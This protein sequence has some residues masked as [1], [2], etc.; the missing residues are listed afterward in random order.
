MTH[1]ATR[2]AQLL[3]YIVEQSK[4]VD[5]HRFK[6]STTTGFVQDR[7]TLAHLPG[8]DFDL[9]TAGDHAWLRVER[10]TALPPPALPAAL[11]EKVLV[12]RDPNGPA[13]HFKDHP[14]VPSRTPVRSPA[15]VAT[16][17][18]ELAL[19]VEPSLA[20][21]GPSLDA[22]LADY[23]GLWTAWAAGESPRRKAIQLYTDLFSLKHQLGA[24]DTARPQEL[25]WGMGVTTWTLRDE[26]GLPVDV[27]YPLLTQ[28]M[29]IA[30]EDG[31]L[32]I[33]L[34]P[35]GVAA[36]FEFDAFSAWQLPGADQVEKVAAQSLTASADRPVTPFDAGSYEPVLKLVAG[37]LHES[38]RYLSGQA[39][40]PVAGESLLVTD[41]WVLLTRPRSNNSLHEDIGRLQKRI[42]DGAPLPAGA[43]AF[44]TAP[45]DSPPPQHDPIA[46]RGLCG[47]GPRDASA[48]VRDLYFPLPYN[49]EQVAILEQLERSAG[50]VVQGPPGTGKTHTIANVVCHYLATGRRVLVTAKGEQALEVLQSKIPAAVR[51]LTVALLS[52]DREGLSSFGHSIEAIIQTVSQLQPETAQGEIDALR[53]AVHSTHAELAV[54]DRCVDD[55]A[56]SQLSDIDVDGVVM[57]AESMAHLVVDGEARHRWFD[58]VLTLEPVHAPP[59]TAAEVEVLR[60]ARRSVGCDLLHANARLPSS[61]SLPDARDIGALHTVL[62]GLRAIDTAEACGGLPALR[63]LS[64]EVLADARTLLESVEIATLLAQELEET[65]YPWAAPLRRKCRLPEFTSERQALESLFAEADGLLVDRLQFLKR[66]VEIPHGAVSS[67]RFTA[68]VWRAAETGKPFGLIAHSAVEARAQIAAVRISGLRPQGETDWSHVSRYL[69]LHDR[70]HSFNVRWNQFAEVLSLPLLEDEGPQAL[71]TT[72]LLARCA[73]KAH[74][75]ATVHDLQ[76]PVIAERVFANA[77]LQ[78]LRGGNAADLR[79]VGDHLRSHLARAELAQA[80]LML[81]TLQH[82]LAGSSGHVAESLRQFVTEELGNPAVGA[83]RAMAV[84]ADLIAEVHRM[85]GMAHALGVINAV[86]N[87]FEQAGAP[88]MARRIRTEATRPAGEDHVLPSTWRDAWNW[89]RLKAHLDSIDGRDELLTLTARRRVLEARLGRLYEELVS[90]SAWLSTKLAASPKVLSALEAC[91]TAIHR[92]GQGTGSNASRYRR[93]AQNAMQDAQAAVP[94]WVMSHAK[95]SETLPALL[96]SF[97]LVIVDEASQ[98][99]LWALPA[100]L[101]GKQMLVVGDDKQVSP[102]GGFISAGRIQELASRFLSGQPHAPSLTPEK[103]LY[104]MAST[105]FAGSKVMLREHFRCAPAII[106]YS[107]A[108]FY[109]GAMQ[110]L[111]IPSKSERLDPPLVDVFVPSGYR[112]ASDLNRP[113]ADAILKQIE[114]LLADPA[115]ANRSLGVVS[116]LGVNQARHIETLVRSSCDPA[117]LIRRRFRCGDARAFQGSE[118]DILFLSMVAAPKSCKALAGNLFTQRFNVAASRAR[119]RMYLVRSV[120]MSDLSP[121]DLRAGLLAHFGATGGLQRAQTSVV[122][123]CESGFERSVYTELFA[124]GFRVFPQVRAGSFFIDLVVEG[125]N[126]SRLAIECDGDEFHRLDRWQADMNR[127]RVLERAG[128]TFWRCFAS[129]WALRK[130]EVVPELLE[131]LTAMGIEPVSDATSTAAEAPR[132]Q[133]EVYPPA[134]PTACGPILLNEERAA[135]LVGK[136][137][138][139]VG[140]HWQRRPSQESRPTFLVLSGGTPQ[141]RRDA[142]WAQRRTV[143]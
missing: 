10:L 4:V 24:E 89:A 15:A 143:R 31:S 127:Q 106:A 11:V 129:T 134:S 54:I 141:A 44:V 90:A 53:A 80:A 96:G 13:P 77:P 117:E 8:V 88:R 71:R 2:L 133:C 1:V 61:I 107:N 83:E 140:P 103:S 91:R 39:A 55:I 30:V 120:Q 126:D 25:V 38:G 33:V 110:A 35:R 70:V 17:N 28:S 84:Y 52:G 76:L 57:R 114:A 20:P 81:S 122:D 97:D 99:D 108:H 47:A 23:V 78:A 79:Q 26:A 87:R 14:L 50:V 131:R 45:D 46:F 113:E 34:R 86:A 27:Q 75:L 139:M 12:S 101:R 5:R 62:L 98:S 102:D 130:D 100:L 37:N 59:V 118:R 92:I 109:N 93:D 135:Y 123:R 132:V 142:R 3:D 18:G 85:E 95:V 63:A 105:M 29:D 94:C 119:E 69:Q 138:P 9:Q 124:R 64:P 60:K 73:R 104:D 7:S 136:A 68:A 22:G 65:G 16:K 40:L 116:L 32:A 41:A 125:E 112:D 111:R 137:D 51:P 19:E 56:T 115:Y 6:L 67:P 121:L 36:R 66:P 21:P 43:A 49:H 58:D 48:P 128:W 74:L 72:E 42:A 82:K